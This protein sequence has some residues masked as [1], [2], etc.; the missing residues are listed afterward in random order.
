MDEVT[1]RRKAAA[2]AGDNAM[3]VMWKLIGNSCYGRLGMNL[4]K[5]VNVKYYSGKDLMKH[6]SVMG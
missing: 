6:V 4:Q 5:H 1:D 2:A 3:S